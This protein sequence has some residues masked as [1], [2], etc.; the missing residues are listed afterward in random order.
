M[1]TAGKTTSER[2]AEAMERHADAVE[3]LVA[4][5]A[6]LVNAVKARPAGGGGG[7]VSHSGPVFGFGKSKGQPVAGAS[8]RD[9][10][11]YGDAACSSLGNPDKERFHAKERA[12]LAAINAELK[13]HGEPAIVPPGEAH[14]DAP[15]NE[16]VP[17]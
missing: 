13:K 14:D 9:L 2:T 5:V 11:Y 1:T 15:Q 3:A 16:D 6:A 8:V 10:Q 4:G 12:L 17:F 7:V